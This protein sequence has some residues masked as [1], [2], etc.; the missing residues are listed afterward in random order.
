MLP[1]S[2]HVKDKKVDVSHVTGRHDAE[3]VKGHIDELACSWGVPF[4]AGLPTFVTHDQG[5]NIVKAMRSDARYASVP[6]MSHMLHNTVCHALKEV[7]A[8]NDALDKICKI[9]TNLNKSPQQRDF[10]ATWYSMFNR[11]G[12]MLD[13]I[14][15]CPTRWNSLVDA[16]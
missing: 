16:A 13:V 11:G 3:T 5:T 8:V 7:R 4:H 1:R 14:T 15:P 6:C 12:T 9:T 10:L 2:F